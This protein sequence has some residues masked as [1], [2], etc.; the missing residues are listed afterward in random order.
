MV[1][2][3]ALV[4]ALSTLAGVWLAQRAADRSADRQIAAERER[5]AEDEHRRL[6]DEKKT[7]AIDFLA[8]LA[9]MARHYHGPEPAPPE[10]GTRMLEADARMK[11]LYPRPI[12]EAA[13]DLL[14]GIDTMMDD[15]SD[16]NERYDAFV[17]SVQSHLDIT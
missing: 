17:A 13:G 16:H 5:R 10:V 15:E 7:A 3:A 8:G 14:V 11:V 12:A 9:E 4:A 2:W 6:V 1:V